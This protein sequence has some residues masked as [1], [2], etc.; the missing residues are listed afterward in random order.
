MFLYIDAPDTGYRTD[1]FAAVVRRMVLTTLA[2][3]FPSTL[4][5]L[6]C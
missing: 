4:F 5:E 3:V 6:P 1:P 2:Y